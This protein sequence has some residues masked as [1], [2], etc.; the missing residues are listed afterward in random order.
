MLKN[1]RPLAVAI[2]NWNTPSVTA[3]C[4]RSILNS[5]Y[6]DISIYLID[7]GSTLENYQ[8]LLSLI[9][10]SVKVFRL[11]SNTGYVG[12]V[13]HALS[14]IVKESYDYALIMNSDTIIDKHAIAELVEASLR[15]QNQCIVTG[16]VYLHENPNSL[17][18]I[19]S[20]YNAKGRLKR[21]AIMT[22]DVGQFDTEEFR[23]MIDDVFWLLPMNIVKIGRA[24]CR[25]R[26]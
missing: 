19:G 25:E 4:V 12:G 10:G 17:Q 18:H 24:S 8:E 26:V 22:E 21:V 13:N 20:N 16:K 6:N 5:S 9:P 1:S 11:N 3:D 7:N 15:H 14:L 2:V 23:D